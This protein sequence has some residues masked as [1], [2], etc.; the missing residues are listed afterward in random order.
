MPD[1]V[2]LVAYN[3]GEARGGPR[4]LRFSNIEQARAF[5]KERGGKIVSRRRAD[6]KPYQGFARHSLDRRRR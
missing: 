4:L 2:V 6:K 1:E 3:P 5:V